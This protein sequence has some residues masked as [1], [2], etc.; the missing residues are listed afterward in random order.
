M[1]LPETRRT[2]GKPLKMTPEKTSGAHTM[3][4]QHRNRSAPRRPAS[5]Y[6]VFAGLQLNIEAILNGAEWQSM[7]KA[8]RTEMLECTENITILTKKINNTIEAITDS[9]S[10]HLVKKLDELEIQLNYIIEKKKICEKNI[11]ELTSSGKSHH[12]DLIR[13]LRSEKLTDDERHRLRRQL[14]D[15]IK[16][17]VRHITINRTLHTPLLP[18]EDG[19][20]GWSPDDIPADD[21]LDPNKSIEI[22]ILYKDGSYLFF[23]PVMNEH[24]HYKENSKIQVFKENIRINNL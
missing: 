1:T 17:I 4:G 13:E 15:Q 6:P 5:N 22:K 7:T 11:A 16:Q 24:F 10:I 23:D 18:D 21:L 2:R 9:S 19:S 8:L 20:G 3:A 14:A 12:D